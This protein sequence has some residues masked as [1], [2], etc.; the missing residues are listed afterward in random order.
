MVESPSNNQNGMSHL[1]FQLRS[2]RAGLQQLLED[3]GRAMTIDEPASVTVHTRDAANDTPLHYAA[4]SGDVRAIEL[5]VAG[6]ADVDAHGA[7]DS[8][9]LLCAIINGHYA[10]ALRLVEL[11]ASPAGS[12]ELGSVAEAAAQSHDLR[13]KALFTG[14]RSAS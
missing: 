5:L 2:V 10:A 6:G 7:C 3:I 4:H 12:S 8:T 14:V 9:P 11:G 13:I 1:I